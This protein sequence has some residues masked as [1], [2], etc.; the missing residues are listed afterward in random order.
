MYSENNIIMCLMRS[1]DETV[2]VLHG[3]TLAMRDLRLLC[4]TLKSYTWIANPLD[5]EKRVVSQRRLETS[6]LYNW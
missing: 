5:M 1:G 2:V 6:N 3:H 4:R